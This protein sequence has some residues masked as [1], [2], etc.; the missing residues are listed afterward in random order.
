[1]NRK[2]RAESCCLP[3]QPG[4]GQ[5]C[6]P[7]PTARPHSQQAPVVAINQPGLGTNTARGQLTSPAF[8]KAL[9]PGSSQQTPPVIYPQV[10]GPSRAAKYIKRPVVLASFASTN[11]AD[12][13]LQVASYGCSP[14]SSPVECPPTTLGGLCLQHSEEQLAWHPEICS[15][16][17]SA[18]WTLKQGESQTKGSN[19]AT[20]RK[21]A[22]QSSCSPADLPQRCCRLHFKPG[23]FL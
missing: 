22:F 8:I 23:W 20:G 19:N 7:K 12:T 9:K 6:P 17:A 14:T 10:L 21:T 5:K 4:Q 1:M 2:S 15:P 3:A 13:K 11:T 16:A 18:S